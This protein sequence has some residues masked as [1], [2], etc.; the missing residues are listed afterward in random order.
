V[1]ALAGDGQLLLSQ[2]YSPEA[3]ARYLHGRRRGLGELYKEATPQPLR[4]YI[5]EFNMDRYEHPLGPS[6]ERLM[7]KYDGNYMEIIR[8]SASPNYSIDRL[9]SGFEPWLRGQ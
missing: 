4:D 2:G 5:F 8:A 1:R 3:V 7:K 9:L 6:F